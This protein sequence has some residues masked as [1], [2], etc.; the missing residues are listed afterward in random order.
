MAAA[1]AGGVALVQAAVIQMLA[2]PTLI[3]SR[4][5]IVISWMASAARS[6]RACGSRVNHIPE[7]ASESLGFPV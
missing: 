6:S 4:R 2:N 1:G 5:I 7:I 3:P